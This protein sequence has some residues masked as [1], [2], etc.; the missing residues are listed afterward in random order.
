MR[1]NPTLQSILITLGP[2]LAVCVFVGAMTLLP[3]SAACKIELEKL[4]KLKT[5]FPSIDVANQSS[6]L[7]EL[8]LE[9]KNLTEQLTRLRS[10]GVRYVSQA[11][12]RESDGA[13]PAQ[14]IADL[15]LLEHHGMRCISCKSN[16]QVNTTNAESS[17]VAAS[18]ID[19]GDAPAQNSAA[20]R[21]FTIEFEGTFAQLQASLGDLPSVS[22]GF[23]IASIAMSE[24]NV[25]SPLRLWKL[26]V[27]V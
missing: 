24:A 6:K 14:S 27:I 15:T 12:G 21:E 20:R 5:Q 26:R 9:S 11:K 2:A 4:R 3:K 13:S 18:R 25:N 16:L 10:S 22:G 19:S 17:K 23:A 8:K 1:P 7:D